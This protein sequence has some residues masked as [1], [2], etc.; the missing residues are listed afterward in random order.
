MWASFKHYFVSTHSFVIPPTSTC[1]GRLQ[2]GRA[3]LIPQDTRS[4]ATADWIRGGH[5]APAQLVQHCSGDMEWDRQLIAWLC[6]TELKLWHGVERQWVC[7]ERQCADMQRQAR[8]WPKC[9][10]A[11]RWMRTCSQK[12]RHASCLL[13]SGVVSWIDTTN[14]INF[15]VSVLHTK[16]LSTF[17]S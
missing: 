11:E 2:L 7:R 3:T 13:R 8:V 16:K 17:D 4:L 5:V 12:P 6:R 10:Q 9:G 15:G 1:L 14:L